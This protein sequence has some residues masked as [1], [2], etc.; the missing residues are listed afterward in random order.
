MN[1]ID[2]TLN[3]DTCSNDDKS[4]NKHNGNT[5]LV[6]NILSPLKTINLLVVES[7]STLFLYVVYKIKLITYH[8]G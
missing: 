8:N 2:A 3:A 5:Y 1:N 7:L 6:N 4:R